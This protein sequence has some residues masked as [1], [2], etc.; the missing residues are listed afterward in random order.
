MADV[1]VE[2]LGPE[3]VP[4][5]V[6]L[7]NQIFRPPRDEEHFQRRYLGRHNVVQMVARLGDRP[8]GFLLGFEQKPRVF[9]TWFYGILPQYR[10]QGIASQLMEAIHSWCKLNDYESIRIECYNQHRPMLH[11]AI[12]HEYDVIGIRWDSDRGDNLIL[13]QKTLSG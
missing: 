5:I 13:F 7:Y 11:M 4:V 3:D 12:H 1:I 6:K 9:F 8:V 2:L 10:R